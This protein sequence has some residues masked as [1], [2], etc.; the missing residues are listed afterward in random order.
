MSNEEYIENLI[1]EMN[2]FNQHLEIRA[3]IQP[4]EEFCGK[5][6]ENASP[7][8]VAKC[9]R[10]YDT[11]RNIINYYL[12]MKKATDCINKMYEPIQYMLFLIGDKLNNY[13]KMS[14]DYASQTIKYNEMLLDNNINF[15]RA[16]I[17][18]VLLLDDFPNENQFIQKLKK[19]I[20][21]LPLRQDELAVISKLSNV[22]MQIWK[23]D[24]LL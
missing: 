16:L 2:M 15:N 5:T 18:S 22:N 8:E 7:A 9:L 14:D 1:N 6:V 13:C 12:Y 4:N 21:Y 10:L 24:K 17:C 23:D 11:A 20:E 19:N 3:G